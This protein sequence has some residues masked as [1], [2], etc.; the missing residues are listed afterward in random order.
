MEKRT[1]KI[2]SVVLVLVMIAS[3]LPIFAMAD[4]VDKTYLVGD[5]FIADAQNAELPTY[6]GGAIPK[7][8]HWEGPVQGTEIDCD[9]IEHTHSADK[10]AYSPATEGDSNFSMPGEPITSYYACFA[11]HSETGDAHE[12]GCEWAPIDADTYFDNMPS[13]GYMADSAPGETLYY[14]WDCTI[15]EHSH[16]ACP[17]KDTYTWTLVDNEWI[18]G[19][20]VYRVYK[21]QAPSPINDG[22][23]A[24]DYGPKGDDTPYFTVSVDR[25]MLEEAGIHFD[26]RGNQWYISTD[27]NKSYSHESLWDVILNAMSA[28][29]QQK[30]MDAFG[31]KY[32]GYVLKQQSSSGGKLSG[33][34]HIDGYLKMSP[35]V[36]AVE[37]FSNGTFVSQHDKQTTATEKAWTYNE[38]IDFLISDFG[39]NEAKLVWN[40]AKDGGTY[41]ASGVRYTFTFKPQATTNVSGKSETPT[42]NSNGTIKYVTKTTDTYYLAQFNFELTPVPTYSVTYMVSTDN[43]GF[44]P[45]G[46]VDKYYEGDNVEIRGDFKQTGFE[47][48][49]W[50]TTDKLTTAAKDFTMGKKDVT[51]YGKLTT[52]P[53]YTITY[54]VDGKL[55]D[56]QDV[57][58][59]ENGTAYSFNIPEGYSFSGWYSDAAY[60]NSVTPDLT[61]VQKDM[62]F[63]GKTT[64]NSYGYTIYYY[65]DSVSQ[66]NF[67]DKIENE[68][69]YN[70]VIPVNKTLYAPAGYT[71]PGT[72]PDDLTIT[73]DNDNNVVNIIYTS[74][75]SY[76]YTVNYYKDSS[77]DEANLL[78]TNSGNAEFNSNFGV[79]NIDSEINDFLPAGYAAPGTPDKANIVIGTDAAENVI[80]VVY[81]KASY[82]VNYYLDNNLIST[83]SHTAK[84]ES[85]VDVADK[86]VKTGYTV[87]D[88]SSTDVTAE[89]LQSG[90]FTMPAKDVEIYATSTA[91]DYTVTY[92]DDDGRSILQDAVIVHTGDRVTKYNGATP[93]KASSGG[94]NYTF[95]KWTLIE[96][97]ISHGKVTD[98]NLVF[99]ASYLGVDAD[100]YSVIYT[101]GFDS[102]DP[103]YN[104]SYLVKDEYSYNTYTPL[105]DSQTINEFTRDGYT[106][107]GWELRTPELVFGSGD[108]LFGENGAVIYYD[109]KWVEIPYTLVVT[110]TVTG[111]E[112]P[113]DFY[114][115]LTSEELE[116]PIIMDLSNYSEL[117]EDNNTYIWIAE[118][119]F[120]G[121]YTATE[122]NYVVEGYNHEGTT[123]GEKRLDGPAVANG[124]V[125]GLI[126]LSNIY[127]AP[128]SSSDSHTLTVNHIGFDESGLPQLLDKE[129]PAPGYAKGAPYTTAEAPF[130]GWSFYE[131]SEDS[132][133][134]AGS[135]EGDTV[136]TYLY[137][138]DS[139]IL[140][141]GDPLAAGPGD[142]VVIIT[143][144]DDPLAP[145]TIVIPED[146]A[147]LS[148]VPQTGDNNNIALMIAIMAA[149]AL[150]VIVL[151][152]P[153]KKRAE[154]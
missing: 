127:S 83:I 9:V 48:S 18:T 41:E 147:P 15:E 55:E 126:A 116:E 101:N 65:K 66:S 113:E 152:I 130:D 77:D 31:G 17:T 99:Q 76:G 40:V 149:C 92:V 24:K 128:G 61:N 19:A 108:K 144:P 87:S 117:D 91:I 124:D 45:H 132:A 138:Q 134:A 39:L 74:K 102:T 70:A 119:L 37:L 16:A 8:T 5:T 38:V 120:I 22:Y 68:A 20:K 121:N 106:F 58:K 47:F 63:Y 53:Q 95:E 146:P 98:T 89:E 148:D 112:L 97:K 109:A 30:F 145:G 21:N 2:L 107:V 14:N 82:N 25:T 154:G 137:T 50:K 135:I 43:G 115:E 71:T 64:I 111:A 93:T 150:G 86:P 60:E 103:A 57:T 129:G 34:V 23:N 67:L 110:K 125:H 131:M 142:E 104:S 1:K 118:G 56:T 3:M 90:A 52:V 13:P 12:G 84:F 54:T 143:D 94:K 72:G 35:P 123:T 62:D 32:V 105:S 27:T 81:Q 4:V 11:D 6:E 136:V 139:E 33:D 26:P 29:D 59:G 114:I 100:K 73:A 28:A 141:D 7:H 80:N 51:I 36:Y 42:V 85:T 44:V 49:G 10:C 122:Y 140:E 69:D 79:E 46:S 75:E 88:W 153:K 151:N 96:G 78:G 133:P